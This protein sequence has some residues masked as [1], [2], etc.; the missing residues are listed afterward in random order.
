M[1]FKLLIIFLFA[2]AAFVVYSQTKSAAFAPAEDFPRGALAY[3]QINDLPAFVK[4]LSESEFVGKYAASRN[5]ADFRNNHLGRKLASRWREFGDAAGFPLDLEIVAGLT[6][7]GAAVAVYDVGKLEFVFVAPVR[8]EI[9]A[10]TE[11]FRRREKFREE[12]LGDGTIVYRAA[13]EADRGRQ[14]QELI[15]ANVE[16]RFVLATSEKLLAQTLK[17]INGDAA[18][19]RLS[20]EPAFAALSEKIDPHLATVW[21]DQAALNDDYYFKRYWLMSDAANLKNIRAGIFD[22]E[23]R[24]GE[25]L[26]HRRFLLDKAVKSTS[27]DSA[28]AGKML[29]LLPENIPFFRLRKIGARTVNEAIENTIFDPRRNEAEQESRSSFYSSFDVTDE[30]EG[31]DY[32]YLSSN[33]DESIDEIETDETIERSEIKIDFDEFLKAAEPRE[34]LTFVRPQILP[35]PLFA[36]FRRASIFRLAAPSNYNR[37]A[38]EAAI[39]RKFTAQ[40]MIAAPNVEFVWETKTENGSARRELKL[41][42]LEWRAVYALRGDLL[43]IA[44]DESF[45]REIVAANNRANENQANRKTAFAEMTVINLSTRK[46][47]YNDVFDRLNEKK[48]ADAFFT[49]NIKSLLD[50]AS[51]I[52]KIEIRKNYSQ[53]ILEEELIF[54]Y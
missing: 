31:E 41:P 36:D 51:G 26:E 23:M 14:K 16:N 35:A 37:Q 45:F 34:V 46:T 13:V 50:A 17:N 49:G 44:N 42:M 29:S 21:V 2:A 3:A 43:I 27:F 8:A 18:K 32:G 38:F 4:L 22:F 28:Q 40:T 15:F 9:F 52:E 30:N 12:T 1:K 5:F 48:A 20:D 33:F 24:E 25:I 11:F 6:E 19:N 10:A 54:N 53:N 47:A 7:G 39:E